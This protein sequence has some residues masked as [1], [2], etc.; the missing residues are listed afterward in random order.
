MESRSALNDDGGGDV[1]DDKRK[2]P[3]KNAEGLPCITWGRGIHEKRHFRPVE[4]SAKFVICAIASSSLPTLP[5]LQLFI[6][7]LILPVFFYC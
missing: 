6:L 3:T 1:D 4:P 7:N 5:Q 2:I